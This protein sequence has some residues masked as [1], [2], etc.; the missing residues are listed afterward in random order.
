METNILLTPEQIPP[1]YCRCFQ[2]DCPKSDSCARFLAGKH[3]PEGWVTGP[4]VYPT[5]RQGAT[6]VCYKQTRIIHAAY[7]FRALFAEVKKK[8]DTPLRDRIKTYWVETPPT[9]ATTTANA[10]SHPS[11]RNGSSTSSAGTAIQT[12]YASTSIA[13]STILSLPDYHGVVASLPRIG[14]H[15]T[16]PWKRAYQSVVG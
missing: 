7:G 6:C 11:N 2:S 1:S 16:T 4:A 15:T 5:A 10:F 12:S 8:D 14:S 13:T 3:L 9:T